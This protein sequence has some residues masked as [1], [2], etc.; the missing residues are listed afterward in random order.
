MK[1]RSLSNRVGA[2]L[3]EYAKNLLSDAA[4]TPLTGRKMRLAG[5][6]GGLGLH[7]PTGRVADQEATCDRLRFDRRLSSST[8][9]RYLRQPIDNTCTAQ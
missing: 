8:G 2:G 5:D 6:E 1:R 4:K 9:A 7:A 3:L